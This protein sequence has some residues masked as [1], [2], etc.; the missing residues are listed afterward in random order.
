[1]PLYAD[2]T[3]GNGWI[4]VL[5]F[6]NDGTTVHVRTYSPFLNLCRTD[7][8]NDFFLSITPLPAFAPADFNRDGTVN[9]A[10]LAIWKENFGR[11]GTATY[12]QGEANGD[13]DVDG[14]FLS[15]AAA[16]IRDRY[17]DAEARPL[18]LIIFSN[19]RRSHS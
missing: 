1:L 18:T 8:A 15:L 11:Y 19:Q 7:A 17:G 5:E 2:Q 6:L 10:D 3:A 4:R 13:N 16:D 9:G 12:Q 14:L